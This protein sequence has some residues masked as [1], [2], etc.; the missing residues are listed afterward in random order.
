VDID[1]FTLNPADRVG[2]PSL[3]LVDISRKIPLLHGAVEERLSG[4]ETRVPDDGAPVEIVVE[5]SYEARRWRVPLRA[6]KLTN[7]THWTFEARVAGHG[8]LKWAIGLELDNGKVAFAGSREPDAWPIRWSADGSWRRAT[9]ALYENGATH[10]LSGRVVALVIE[11]EAASGKA[12]LAFRDVSNIIPTPTAPLEARKGILA[13]RILH[14][15]TLKPVA[16]EEILCCWRGDERRTRTDESGYYRFHELPHRARCQLTLLGR[17]RQ[18]I[19]RRGRVAHIVAD[20]WDWDI[21][22]CG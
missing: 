8:K 12:T 15:E 13:G 22:V 7:A 9:L 17:D 6:A 10:R 4:L 5:P 3:T 2:G 20:Y 21:L 11:V 19:F 16:D 14:C 1:H 18:A